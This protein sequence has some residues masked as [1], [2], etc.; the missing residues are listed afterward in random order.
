MRT[1]DEKAKNEDIDNERVMLS[2]HPNILVDRAT[3]TDELIHLYPN[4]HV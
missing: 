1:G 3:S 2:S 4:Q